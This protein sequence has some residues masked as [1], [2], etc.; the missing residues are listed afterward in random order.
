MP[1]RSYNIPHKLRHSNVLQVIDDDSIGYQ[2]EMPLLISVSRE[3]RPSHPHHF[4]AGALNV[5]FPQKFYNISKD[6]IYDSQLRSTFKILW[7]GFDG[8]KGPC[9]SGTCFF[10]KRDALYRTSIQEGNDV[11]ILE[12]SFGLSEDFIKC[13]GQKDK[14]NVTSLG[15]SSSKVL[16]ETLLLASC[17]YENQPKWG[18]EAKH[19]LRGT[20]IFSFLLLAPVVLSYVPQLCLVN[21]ISLYPEVS[22]SYFMLFS[23]IFISSQS[24]HMQEVLSTGSS[25]QTWR[26]EQRV[27]MMK[28]VTSHLYGSLDAIM[29]RLGIK[30]SSFLLTNKIVDDEQVERYHMGKFDFQTS[31]MLVVPLCTLVN[32]NVASLIWGFAKAY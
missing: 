29:E 24:K 19:V 17:A 9:L 8:L 30:Q 18:E 16:Q 26:N 6:D 15:D 3:K 5:L 21:G 27:W 2:T 7:P 11:I 22:N 20:C 1:H 10:I 13:L 12:H 25:I 14:A 32:L 23:L 4:K 31:T 28:S